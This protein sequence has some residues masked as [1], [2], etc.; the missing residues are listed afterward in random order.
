M[1]NASAF[2]GKADP[3]LEV[4]HPHPLAGGVADGGTDLGVSAG[5][6]LRSGLNIDGVDT[7]I[8]DLIKK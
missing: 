5:V 7:V 3:V 1:T 6:D 2:L 8:Q 4:L